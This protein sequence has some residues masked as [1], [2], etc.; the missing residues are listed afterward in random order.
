MMLLIPTWN[1]ADMGLRKTFV[2]YTTFRSDTNDPGLK[3]TGIHYVQE[4]IQ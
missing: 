1:I 4:Q 3:I 2:V